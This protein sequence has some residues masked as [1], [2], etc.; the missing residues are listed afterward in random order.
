M[1]VFVGCDVCVC[2]ATGKLMGRAVQRD[3]HSSSRLIRRGNVA[4]SS[5]STSFFRSL[6]PFAKKK[7]GA[8][9]W[10]ERHFMV[11][12]FLCGSHSGE[13]G[14]GVCDMAFRLLARSLFDDRLFVRL[15]QR[16][17]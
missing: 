1:C 14:R 6:A 2:F 16:D 5:L 9:A 13:G 7:K 3:R 4:H 15:L 10:N 12:F 17:S 8:I 11:D